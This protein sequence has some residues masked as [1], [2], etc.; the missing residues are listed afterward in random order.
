MKT[1]YFDDFSGISGDMTVGALIDLGVPVDRLRAELGKLPL[2]GYRISAERRFVNGIG[3]TKFD[4]AIEHDHAPSGRAGEH[5]HHPGHGSHRHYR[6]IRAMLEESSLEE[7][8]RETAL[9]IFARLAAAE[10]RVHGVPAEDVAFHEVGAVDSIVDIVGA[11]VGFVELGVERFL[12]GTLPLG[13]GIVRSQHGPIP[14]PGPATAELL[15]G[16]VT[17]PDDGA[18]EL[19]TPTGAAVIAALADQH[20]TEGFRI[21][22]VGYGAGSK[23]LDDRPNL[24]RLMLGEVAVA[25]GHDDIVQIEANIDDA[26][27]EI[28]DHVME[29]LFAA[30]ARDVFLTP[31][32]MKKNRPATQ[33]SV[34]CVPADRERIA[35]IMLRET[36]TIGVRYAR[37]GRTLLSRESVDVATEYGEVRVKVAIAPDGSRNLAPE[38]DDCRRRADEHGVPVKLVLQAAIAAAWRG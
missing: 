15:A 25:T 3:A 17:R 11:A 6:D 9:R 31:I 18:G 37:L 23:V 29:R 10:G 5:H 8:V 16:F 32:L 7:R 12:V 38:F 35:G 28:F 36:T 33:L 27:P 21:D 1:L 34:L 26:S 20:P 4:V 19:I 30:G 24:L 22:A 13:S 2:A 14:V